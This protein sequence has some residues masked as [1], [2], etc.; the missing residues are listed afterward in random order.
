MKKIEKAITTIE[1]YE[2][3]TDTLDEDDYS[4]CS[5]HAIWGD[6]FD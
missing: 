4:S 6:D 2:N 3:N 1:G 5:Y